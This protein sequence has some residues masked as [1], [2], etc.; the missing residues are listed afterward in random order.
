MSF[1]NGILDSS[2][3]ILPKINPPKQ[4]KPSLDAI[5]SRVVSE[6]KRK[7]DLDHAFSS[8]RERNGTLPTGKRFKRGGRENEG[9]EH[10]SQVVDRVDRK[11]K[12][13]KIGVRDEAAI[14]RFLRLSKNLG[15]DGACHAEEIQAPLTPPASYRTLESKALSGQRAV[16][17]PASPSPS[18]LTTPSPKSRSSGTERDRVDL[19]NPFIDT[20]FGMT[21]PVPVVPD[22]P[23]SPGSDPFREKLLEKI[24]LKNLPC[25]GLEDSGSG[26][27]PVELDSNG[28]RNYLVYNFKGKRIAVPNDL[29]GLPHDPREDLSPFNDEYR[30]PQGIKP[31]NLFPRSLYGREF[32]RNARSSSS[33]TLKGN[34]DEDDPFTS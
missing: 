7:L 4:A 24:K 8:L 21:R 25:D 12:K 6:K 29:F 15:L 3:I 27:P 13:A 28:E 11:K 19:S 16:S 5:A 22:S 17:E 14:E 2:P 26:L 33:S 23:D 31:R 30:T 1:A 9:D 20:P 10:P 34:V 32:K 18:P